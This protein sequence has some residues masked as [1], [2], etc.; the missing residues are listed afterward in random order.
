MILSPNQP[1]LKNAVRDLISFLPMLAHDEA[2]MT[3]IG[4]G[5]KIPRSHI[6]NHGTLPSLNLHRM[7][8]VLF[9]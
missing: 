8:A 7:H 6:L 9:R 2:N 4:A 3:Q 1:N 5:D